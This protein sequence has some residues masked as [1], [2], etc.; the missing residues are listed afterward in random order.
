[1]GGQSLFR[2]GLDEEKMPEGFDR[3]SINT[4]TERFPRHKAIDGVVWSDV[5]LDG[6]SSQRL[7]EN[8]AERGECQEG[9]QRSSA[10]G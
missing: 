9:T 1:M 7:R 8:Q 5:H 6:L 3:N 2:T 4:G 10:A